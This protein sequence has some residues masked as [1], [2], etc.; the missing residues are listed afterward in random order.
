LHNKKRIGQY[1]LVGGFIWRAI[2]GQ[3]YYFCPKH[4][5]QNHWPWASLTMVY[6]CQTMSH[7]PFSGDSW[8]RLFILMSC[9]ISLCLPKFPVFHKMSVVTLFAL[10]IKLI[11]V[12]WRCVNIR[13]CLTCNSIV[14]TFLLSISGI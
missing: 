3:I 1:Q 14:L 13:I 8:A 12:F 10:A 2:L 7:W 11:M 4:N 6:N 5:Y 9:Q